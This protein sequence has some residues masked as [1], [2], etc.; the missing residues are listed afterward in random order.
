MNRRW[1]AA[2]TGVIAVP[3]AVLGVTV[4]MVMSTAGGAAEQASSGGCATGLVSAYQVDA[5]QL[6]VAQRQNAATIIG[7]GSALVGVQGEIIGVATALVESELVNVD[8][9]DRD[10]LGLF[11]QRASQGWGTPAE[12]LDPADAATMFFDALLK[13][14]GWQQMDPGMAAQAVQRSAFPDRYDMRMAEA[15]TIVTGATAGPTEAGCV[16][17]IT[18]GAIPAAAL[19]AIE[20]APT[21]VQ[22]AIAYAAAQVG[23]V[24]LWG[25]EGPCAHGYDCSGLIQMAYA[26][27]GV[28]IGRTTYQQIGDGITIDSEADLQ[29]G[30]ILFPD[31]GHE[32]LYIGAGYIIEAP[33][34]GTVVRIAPIYSMAAGARRIVAA[35]AQ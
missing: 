5:S 18:A 25:G 15:K 16:T 10:S 27:A 28:P 32:V 22:V 13:V 6:T 33:H 4:A 31:A 20:Q 30:D 24:Y 1:L 26:A 21:Q 12:E 19:A 2:A 35:E 7:V 29:P 8:H 3:V 9:G 14:P 34:T 11:Q 17:T 23:C